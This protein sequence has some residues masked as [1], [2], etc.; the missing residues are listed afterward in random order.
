[1]RLAFASLRFACFASLRFARR[2]VKTVLLAHVSPL[3]TSLAQTVNTLTYA[4]FMISATNAAKEKK[5][6]AGPEV[7]ERAKRASFEE[8]EHTSSY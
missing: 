5:K 4:T 8:D 2:S 7:S 6:F 1:M 3:R